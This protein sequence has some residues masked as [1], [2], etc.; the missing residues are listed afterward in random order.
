MTQ[1][2]M[3]KMDMKVS[4]VIEM[5]MR[6]GLIIGEWRERRGKG[7]WVGTREEGE[8]RER[9]RERGEEKKKEGPP[10]HLSQQVGSCSSL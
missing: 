3:I 1:T 9:E 7:E 10:T 5:E 2:V 4:M 6:V 8:E